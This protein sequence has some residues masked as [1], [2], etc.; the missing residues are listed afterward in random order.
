MKFGI[1]LPNF[2]QTAT[3]LSLI[4]TINAAESLGFDSAWLTDHI[5]LPS[6]ESKGF[7]HIFESI[8]SMAYLAAQTRTIKLGLSSLVLPQRNP[9]EIAKSIATIDVLSG[10]RIMIATG[11]GWSEGEY[12]N[13]GSNFSNRGQ[14][15]TEAV[16]VLRT[17]WRGQ[18]KASF[19]GQFYQFEE[20]TFSPTPIQ[21]GGPPLWIAGNSM[22]ALKRAVFLADGW[23][24]NAS[25]PEK[26][27]AKLDQVQPLI[28]NR[29]FTISIRFVLDFNPK[30]SSISNLSG[31]SEKI[32]KD[33][34]C[35]KIMG[36]NYAI[37]EFS[38][39]SQSERERSMRKFVQEVIP[40]LDK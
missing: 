15:M 30:E 38:A 22:P 25:T 31:N 36:M 29:P 27:K 17:L 21:A 14:R 32:I 8:S 33:L 1:I 19:K 11:I 35:Y 39:N 26:I 12:K 16:R 4:D 24:P 3:R 37:I 18:T 2:G 34:N 13:L 23:H 20:M 9:M 5:A 7:S 40:N 10:G 28:Q 6:S